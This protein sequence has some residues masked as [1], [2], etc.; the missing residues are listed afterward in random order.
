MPTHN[1]TNVPKLS[2]AQQAALSGHLAE[3][4]FGLLAAV[5]TR[6]TGAGETAHTE[7]EQKSSG[8][9]RSLLLPDR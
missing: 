3:C 9:Y 1:G 4:C 5:S 6:V 8:G 2:G 7:R